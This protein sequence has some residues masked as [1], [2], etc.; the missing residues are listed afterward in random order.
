MLSYYL[1]T[2]HPILGP[3]DADLFI[4]SLCSGYIQY[5]SPFLISALF[6]WICV[7]ASR[8]ETPRRLIATQQ[9]Y[10]IVSSHSTV[11]LGAQFLEEA[12][13]RWLRVKGMEDDVLT[14]A[15]CMILSIALACDGK[16]GPSIEYKN[17]GIAIAER[18]SMFNTVPDPQDATSSEEPSANDYRAKSH[19]AWGAY[20]LLCHHAPLYNDRPPRIPPGFHTPR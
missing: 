15:A 4:A 16:D 9:G 13:R 1:Q 3:F 20:N 7:S 8:S 5:C 18:L 6:Y 10:N 11:A 12:E 14:V 2:D 17:A 19:I